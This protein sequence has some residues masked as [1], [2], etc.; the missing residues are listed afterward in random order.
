MLSLVLL[1]V[2]SDIGFDKSKVTTE[3]WPLAAAICK[4][5][6]WKK[7]VYDRRSLDT[8]NSQEKASLCFDVPVADTRTLC[9][10]VL[11]PRTYALANR[12][13]YVP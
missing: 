3:A 5:V 13:H 2:I 10:P 8:I 6:F 1:N 7:K 4:A 9:R 12:G 11:L